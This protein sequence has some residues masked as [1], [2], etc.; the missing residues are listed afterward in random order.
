MP[1]S[2][3]P[4][5]GSTEIA[6]AREHVRRGDLPKAE[7]AYRRVLIESPDTLEA[8][9]FL[10]NAALAHGNPA[11]AVELLSRAAEAHR[12]NPEIL[13]E[14]GAA[15]RAGNRFDAARYVLERAIE[16]RRGSYPA[17]RLLLANV[18]EMDQRPD[19]SLLHYFKAI[20]QAQ[21]AGEWLDD[22][23]TDPTLR[24]L[25]LHAMRY[26][27][28]ERR[29]LF[30]RALEPLRQNTSEFPGALS[31]ID[32]ALGAYLRDQAETPTD[33]LQKPTFLFVPGLTT[34]KFI[35]NIDNAAF[36]WLGECTRTVSGLASESA[37]C[38]KAASEVLSA[39]IFSLDAL[40]R[41]GAPVAE[42]SEEAAR[43]P[44]YQRGT[45]Q[46]YAREGA[47]RLVAAVEA[48]P[49]VYIPRHGPDV[50]IISLRNRLRL[51]LAY[52]RS[53]A[54]LAA[55]IG[56]RHSADMLIIVGGESRIL[57]GGEA[58]VFDPSYGYEYAATSDE[59]CQAV[60][61]E[62]WHPDLSPIERTALIS[63][64]TTAVEF[65][66]RLQELN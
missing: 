26:V 18:L 42:R 55:I 3:P 61:F 7:Q 23:S 12:D 33:P 5:I 17:A 1:H 31:R 29:S 58:I 8:L 30:E 22:R 52:G 56:M 51:P 6:T 13:V 20:L 4:L 19:L 65:D 62:I 49:L 32:R 66:C 64:A 43:A 39:P 27:S 57:R 41:P 25:V 35:D 28:T 2:P 59:L 47:P 9:R 40:L 37:S 14:L 54:R 63:I 46:E 15:Y 50:E 48:A 45:L 44:V 24:Q 38:A 11:E 21:S 36:P 60:S 34:G 16:L 53:N 10:G